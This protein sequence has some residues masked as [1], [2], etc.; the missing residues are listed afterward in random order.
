MSPARQSITI[1]K[2]WSGHQIATSAHI[3]MSI[4]Y[5]DHACRIQIDAPFYNDPK[6]PGPRGPTPNLW[7]YEVVEIFFVGED[8]QYLEL[9]FSPHGHYLMLWLSA[10]RVVDDRTLT[11]TYDASFRADRWTGT[12]VIPRTVMPT[13]I[14]RVNAFAISGLGASRQY[15]AWHPLP[16]P[17]PDFHQPHRF[18]EC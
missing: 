2:T 18:P 9:E 11:C 14:Q 13:L 4:E 17:K 3:H 1:E 16:G 10:P 6:P 15:L 12:A 7:D 8:G 5:D